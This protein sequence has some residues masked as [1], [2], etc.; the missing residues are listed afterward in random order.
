MGKISAGRES[1]LCLFIVCKRVGL[2]LKEGLK[3]LPAEV[4]EPRLSNLLLNLRDSIAT[5]AKFS[6]DWV[7]CCT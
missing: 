2:R 6:E 1:A 7:R 4:D 5:R 3:R